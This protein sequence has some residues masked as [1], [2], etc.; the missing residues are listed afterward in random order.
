MK[1]TK[2]QQ[3]AR[4]SR[5][6]AASKKLDP[7]PAPSLPYGD[8][9]PVINYGNRF[10]LLKYF[11][12]VVA[13]NPDVFPG[14]PFN[15]AQTADKLLGEQRQ[16][17]Q[18]PALLKQLDYYQQCNCG[19]T[20]PHPFWNGTEL[21]PDLLREALSLCPEAALINHV[22]VQRALARLYAVAWHGRGPESTDAKRQLGELL[23]LPPK[24]RPG[25][26]HSGR[27]PDPITKYLPEIAVKFRELR[28]WIR[29][30]DR[31]MKTDFPRE[32]DR[33]QKLAELYDENTGVISAALRPAEP[34][35]L[36]E[37]LAAVLGK[38]LETARKA[39]AALPAC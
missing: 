33:V 16:L 20:N 13:G 3:R 30:S 7:T 22:V 34:P 39:V 23:P 26:K 25:K 11:L 15:F 36:A 4:G 32:I 28:H 6:V 18:H 24:P 1:T 19:D 9:H 17:S 37:R 8:T 35:F 31:L 29:E 21:P 14:P 27:S 5:R 10:A 2:R 38:P 12:P